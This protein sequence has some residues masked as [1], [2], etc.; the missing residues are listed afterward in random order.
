L[1]PA[2]HGLPATPGRPRT[3]FCPVCR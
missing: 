1:C 2:R 3:E